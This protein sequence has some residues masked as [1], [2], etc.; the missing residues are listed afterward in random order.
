MKSRSRWP[1]S[2]RARRLAQHSVPWREPSESR[3]GTETKA[4]MSAD[5]VIGELAA[6]RVGASVGDHFGSSPSR[7]RR[8]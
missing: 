3:T 8:Q 1:S 6:D 5:A 2:G 7:I 4:P